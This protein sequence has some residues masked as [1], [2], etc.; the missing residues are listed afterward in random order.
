MQSRINYLTEQGINQY[1]S[2]KT[3]VLTSDRTN[4]IHF[5]ANLNDSKFHDILIKLK[6]SMSL[7]LF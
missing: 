5:Y 2:V 7:L 6:N 3:Y 4:S 1:I